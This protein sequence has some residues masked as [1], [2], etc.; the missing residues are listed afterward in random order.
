MGVCKT[1]KQARYVSIQQ[2]IWMK[3]GHKF[4]LDLEIYRCPVKTHKL[5]KNSSTFLV[6]R[7]SEEILSSL[8]YFRIFLSF[9]YSLP[10]TDHSS[11]SIPALTE[12]R[13]KVG[14]SVKHLAP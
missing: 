3:D 5:I 12:I 1:A 9:F 8:I 11:A 2:D 7:L 13:D 6:K 10:L 14:P 4:K